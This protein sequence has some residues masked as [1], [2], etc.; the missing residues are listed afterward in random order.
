MNL[1]PF[2]KVIRLVGVGTH[3]ARSDVQKVIGVPG[4][5]G[6]ASADFLALF[7]QDD[8]GIRADSPRK[9]GSKHRSAC[10]AAN[11]ADP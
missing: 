1:K 4:G 11:D 3:V 8:L 2:I 5:K 7:N 10:P 6:E 9:A